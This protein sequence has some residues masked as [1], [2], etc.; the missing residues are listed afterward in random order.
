MVFDTENAD[1][2]AGRHGTSLGFWP[3]SNVCLSG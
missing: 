2:F 3:Q 1:L